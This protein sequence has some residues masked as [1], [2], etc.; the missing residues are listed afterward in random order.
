MQIFLVKT[1]QC[2]AELELMH[3]RK[4]INNGIR[5]KFINASELQYYLDNGWKLG[6]VV[7]K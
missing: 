7:N 3:G 4:R 5:N 1:I 6:G 2:M